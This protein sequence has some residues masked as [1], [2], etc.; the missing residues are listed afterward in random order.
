MKIKILLFFSVIISTVF[1]CRLQSQNTVQKAIY[2]VNYS[3]GMNDFPANTY[4]IQLKQKLLFNKNASIYSDVVAQEYYKLLNENIDFRQLPHIGSKGSVYKSG[5]KIIT[6]LPID[7]QLFSYEEPKLK[8]ELVKGEE[9]KLL[10][11]KVFLAKTITDNNQVFFAWYAPDILIPEGPFR[12]KSLPGLILEVY[13]TNKT[14]YFSATEI[15]KSDQ[16]I[17]PLKQN[18]V[19]VVKEKKQYLKTRQDFLKNPYPI[20]NDFI[21]RDR[22]AMKEQTKNIKSE[23]LLD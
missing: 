10:G 14:I 9:K 4:D 3:L 12:F 17:E 5:D 6:T 11:Y 21:V 22:R 7:Q 1:F 19:I 23:N 16:Q 18:N 2:E 8:W 13:N 15:K 20:G